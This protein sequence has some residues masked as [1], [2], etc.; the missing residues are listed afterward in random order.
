[1]SCP[2]GVVETFE[3]GL[4]AAEAVGQ[5]ARDTPDRSDADTGHVV[6]LAIGKALFQVFDH[7]PAVDQRLKLGRRTEILEEVA[8]LA[9]VLEAEN[10]L[11]QGVFGASNATVRFV[12][13]GLHVRTNVIAC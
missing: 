11:E 2:S 6:D 12:T 3:S 5:K 13:V 1:M 7:L 10:S 4:V 8:A 9:D